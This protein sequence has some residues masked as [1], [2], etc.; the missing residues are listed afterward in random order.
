MQVV[1]EK[2]D[3]AEISLKVEVP[4]EKVDEEFSLAFRRLVKDTEVPGFRKGR[5]PRK[6]FEK[7]F[8]KEIIQE[9]TIKGLYPQIYKEIVKEHKLIPIVDPK[10]QVIQLSEGKPLV[11]KIDLITRPETKLGKYKGIKVK[12]EKIKVS[13]DEVTTVLKQLQL[14]H[15]EYV[16]VGEERE[17]R[18]GDWII[19]DWQAFYKGE[20]LSGKRGENDAFQLG[21]SALPSS[22]SQGLIGLKSG[23][24]KELEVKFPPQHSQRDFA[25]RKITF[26][27]IVKEVKEKI[28]PPLDDE[29]AKDLK[30]DNLKSLREHIEKSLKQAKENQE[31]KRLKE[32]ILKKVIK[33]TQIQVPLSLEKRNVEERIK[34]LEHDLKKQGYSLED[35]LKEGKLSE[36]KL[37]ERVRSAV[38]EEFKTFFVLE[39]IAEE[40]NIQVSEE[41][42]KE[43][44]KLIMEQRRNH[45]LHQD[46]LYSLI[47]QMRME[48]VVEFLY[49]KAE[50]SNHSLLSTA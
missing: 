39:A 34:K 14:Q 38:R 44:L 32:E 26:K 23:S 50:I 10:L 31:R 36:E 33:D 29:F 4:K 16:S 25:G 28:L 40:E 17:A 22:F 11:L 12:S 45:P 37:R 27:I 2:K 13:E 9:E 30:F 43:R 42:L 47:E 21:S 24:R 5:I 48:K 1:V 3:G 6:I 20:K 41:E 18:K 46:K 49:N 7:R 8:G 19:L 15:A 35:Y